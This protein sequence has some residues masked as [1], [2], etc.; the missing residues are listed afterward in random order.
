MTNAL[1]YATVLA[2]DWGWHH[3]DWG[4]GWWVV[5]GLGMVLFWA[6]VI[7]AIVWLVRGG[8]GPR[9]HVQREDPLEI[10][11]RRLAAG[12]ISVDEYE[13]RRATLKKS[14]L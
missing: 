8:L 12:E 13:Q 6:L 4:G 10:L 9:D 3:G 14:A 5:M 1:L 7:V 11:D 2:D